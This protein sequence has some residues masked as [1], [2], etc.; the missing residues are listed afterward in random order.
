M[1]RK[2]VYLREKGAKFTEKSV[3]VTEKVQILQK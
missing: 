1:Y 2:S 3:K